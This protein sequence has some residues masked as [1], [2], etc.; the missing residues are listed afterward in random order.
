MPFTAQDSLKY[1]VSPWVSIA[2]VIG[3]H[4]PGVVYPGPP[5]RSYRPSRRA[6]SVFDRRVGLL[7]IAPS[8]VLPRRPWTIGKPLR[9][10]S[11]WSYR[12]FR[13]G[14]VLTMTSPKRQ[15]VD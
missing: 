6:N 4:L 14:G 11:G 3:D 10:Q 13:S 9:I 2:R 12:G 7:L 1:R 8:P 5:R 15:R